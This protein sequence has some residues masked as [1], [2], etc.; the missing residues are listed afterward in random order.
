MV[1]NFFRNRKPAEETAAEIEKLGRKALVVKANVGDIEAIETS[2]SRPS[3]PFGG[4]DI[5]VSNAASGYNRPVMEQKVEGM[6]LDDGHQRPGLPVCR[7]GSGAAD[8]ETRRRAD[9][10]DHQP[11]AVTG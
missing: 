11:R 1:V 3:R 8:G 5:F 6:G 10:G 2:S 7:P 9:R 4:L